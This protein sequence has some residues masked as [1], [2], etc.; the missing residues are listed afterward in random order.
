MKYEDPIYGEV[1]FTELEKKIIEN[2]GMQRLKKVH[3]NGADF[4]VKPE[5]DTSRFEHSL[6][7]AILCKKFGADED[8]VIAGLVHD[9]SHTA[10]SHLADQVFERRDQTFHED[11]HER[12][13]ER[14]G[15]DELVEEHGYDPEYIFDEENFGILERD[16][17]D[18]CADRLDYTLRDLYKAGLI[19]QETV[20]RVLEGLTT[21]DGLIVAKDK[22]KASEV[23]N[24]FFKL[25]KEVFFDKKSEGTKM[26]MKNILSRGLDEGVITEEDLFTTDQ[27]VMDKL[28]QDS[29]LNE[30]LQGIR[31]G[32]T[33]EDN[34]EYGFKVTRKH[35][36]VDPKIKS[37]NKRLTDV[38]PDAEEKFEKFKSEVPK[39]ASYVV[40]VD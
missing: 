31:N 23:M 26:L 10:F 4:L 37:L 3:Q 28:S 17:P 14:Y 35:R 6:G 9:I 27:E 5:M 29:E 25:N 40:K 11:H 2:P 16:R 24:L 8:E 1:Q 36:I 18:I 30:K 22:E 13:V 7:V 20:D 33:I 21:E 34:G 19:D 15:L 12:F 38:E 39:E 32:L